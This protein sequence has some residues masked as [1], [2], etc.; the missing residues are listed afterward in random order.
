[1]PVEL[2]D[3][4]RVLSEVVKSLVDENPDVKETI[5]ARIQPLLRGGARTPYQQKEL[6]VLLEIVP[7]NVTTSK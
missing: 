6:A 1:M 7:S 3:Q 5:E 4:V 2:D